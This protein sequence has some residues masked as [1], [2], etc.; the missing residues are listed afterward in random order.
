M[1][2]L[3]RRCQAYTGT[4]IWTVPRVH[5]DAANPLSGRTGNAASDDFSLP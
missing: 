4:E 5:Q 1:P 2:V 3:A